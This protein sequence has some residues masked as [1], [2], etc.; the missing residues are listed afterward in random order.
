MQKILTNWYATSDTEDGNTI[1]FA[2]HYVGGEDFMIC[3]DNE[4]DSK[5]AAERRAEELNRERQVFTH[6]Y[7]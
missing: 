6:Q 2:A 4:Y 3:D 1:W 7:Y 5:D